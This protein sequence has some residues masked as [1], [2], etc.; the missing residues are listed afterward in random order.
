MENQ[1][2]P[3]NQEDVNP[4]TQQDKIQKILD[5]EVDEPIPET[6]GTGGNEPINGIENVRI[7]KD[8]NEEKS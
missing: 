8:D 5:G 7:N 2:N 1:I 6:T 3:Q 4:S